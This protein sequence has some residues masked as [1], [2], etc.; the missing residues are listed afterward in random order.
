MAKKV[1]T[2]ADAKKSN[3]TVCP[4]TLAKFMSKAAN[5][6]LTADGKAIPFAAEPKEFSTGSFGWR[7]DGKHRVEID[8]IQVVVQMQGNFIIVN[9]KDASRS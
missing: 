7:L 4:I 1:N 3:K 5:M 2:T 6:E 9:S 8:G